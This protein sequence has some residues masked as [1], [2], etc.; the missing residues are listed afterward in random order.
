MIMPVGGPQPP[1]DAKKPASASQPQ[2]SAAPP[3]LPVD[4]AHVSEDAQKAHMTA[5]EV[6]TSSE[7]RDRKVFELRSAILSGTYELD[8]DRIAERLLDHL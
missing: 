8:A 5:S 1:Q 2:Q 4:E 7:I 3:R 6:S